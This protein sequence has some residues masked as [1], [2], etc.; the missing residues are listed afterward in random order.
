MDCRGAHVAS[1]LYLRGGPS[2]YHAYN[3][4]SS[5]VQG[6][7]KYDFVT[8][9]KVTRLLGR[10]LPPTVSPAQFRRLTNGSSMTAS[11]QN[12]KFLCDQ[13]VSALA[14]ILLQKSKIE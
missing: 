12:A 2:D 4:R 14:S 10:E 13:L 11:G 6:A 5:S 9:L 8:D 3:S 1:V 7:D